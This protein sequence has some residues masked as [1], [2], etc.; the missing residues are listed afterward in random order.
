LN[1]SRWQRIE[2]LFA[3]LIAQPAEARLRLLETLEPDD[4]S[5]R[6]EVASLLA[7]HLPD[8]PLSQVVRGAA[9]STFRI[10]PAEGM[11]LGAY[12]V[13]RKLGQGGMGTV[14]LAV[15]ADDQYRQQVAIKLLS[16]GM[17]TAESVERFR[18]ERQILASLEHPYIARLLDGGAAQLAGFAY[19]TPYFVMEHVEG[20]AVNEYCQNHRL[21]VAGRL[22][23][24]LKICEA[25][26]YAH[27]KLVVHRDLKPGNILVTAEG[28]PKLLDFGV[29]KLLKE[30]GVSGLTVAGSSLTPDFASPEQVLAEQITTA[31]DVYSLGAIL[32]LLLTGVKPHRFV[33]HTTREIQQVICE[34]DPQKL[35]DAA[36]Q[37]RGQLE[38]DLEAI[39]SMAM[40]KE[41][42]RRYSSVEQLSADLVRYLD[43]WPVTARPDNFQYRAGKYVRR[44]KTAIAAGVLIAVALA[45]GTTAATLEARQASR[46]QLRAEQDR[47]R[48][49][50]SQGQAEASRTRAEASQRDAL[51]QAQEATRQR[52]SADA[53]RQEAESQKAGAET[54]R[55][56]AERRFDQVHQLA[57][58]FLMDFHNQISRLPGSTP[59]RKMMIQTGLTYYDTLVQEAGNNREL[60]EEIASGYDRLG[61]VQG[62]PAFAN[63]GDAKGALASY[64]KALAIRQKIADP[65]PEFWRDQISNRVRFSQVTMGQVDYK[66]AE[67]ALQEAFQMAQRSPAADSLEVQSALSQAYGALGDLRLAQSRRNDAIE[68]YTKQLDLAVKLAP[69]RTDPVD[70]EARISLAHTKLGDVL[71]VL[72]RVPESL[73]HLHLA[74]EIDKR[75]ADSNPTNTLLGRKVYITYFLLG[76][77][78]SSAMGREYARPGELQAC[79]EQS[80]ILADKMAAADPDNLGALADVISSASSLG[81][82][83]RVEKRP[84]EALAPLNK[85]VAAAEHIKTLTGQDSGNQDSLILSHRRLATALT[86]AGKYDEAFDHYTKAENYLAYSESRNPGLLRN[87]SRLAGILEGKAEWFAAQLRWNEAAAAFEKLIAMYEPLVARDPKNDNYLSDRPHFYVRLADSYA[88]VSRWDAAVTAMQT[89][90]QRFHEIETNRPL[91]KAEEA[92]RGDAGVKLAKWSHR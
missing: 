58:K 15:R 30:D 12:L 13:T 24:F 67:Q 78:L 84:A 18:R 25:V 27:R 49:V 42:E 39:V 1:S 36:P 73:E 10:E 34:T 35:S 64:G 74:L 41:P 61:D 88:A 76:R 4:E 29:A 83:L 9:A 68:P 92:E 55:R 85:A 65:S 22:R 32:Y 37:L 21:D 5:L 70:A 38:G 72:K 52:E 77:T 19:E 46:A 33:T 82:W 54:Q 11:R 45:G 80:S 7:C 79:L 40:R 81:D 89:A 3:E 16:L 86:D 23:L 53:Q 90:L 14:Y 91:I 63:L 51:Q 43:G 26:A 66:S 57:G 20:E 71:G 75:L 47:E 44:N 17:E 60:L 2:A 69:R 31:T 62:N 87:A 6:A 56:I 50:T 59:A 8:Q 48:A 28:S